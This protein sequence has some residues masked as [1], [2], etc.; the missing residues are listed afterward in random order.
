MAT[1][2]QPL[3]SRIQNLGSRIQFLASSIIFAPHEKN[4]LTIN[5]VCSS[6]ISSAFQRGWTKSRGHPLCRQQGRVPYLRKSL[7][8][9]F[10]LWTNKSQA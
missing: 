5:P 3:E 7:R 1:P 6:K 2:I 10:A 9:I 8:K 4:H